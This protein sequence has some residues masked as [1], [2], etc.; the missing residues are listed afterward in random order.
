MI[1]IINSLI[2]TSAGLRE[3]YE[4]A[5]DGEV[6]SY[7]GPQRMGDTRDYKT[8][9]GG[10]LM[11]APGFV[12]THT[13]G[14][15]G[16]DFMDANLEGNYEAIKLHLAH[17]STSLMPT[18]VSSNLEE[19]SQA[20]S[21]IEQMESVKGLPSLL[22]VHIEGPYC[23]LSQS[24]AQNALFL[25]N[26][27]EEEYSQL[28][29]KHPTIKK[30]TIA[31]ELPGAL[32]MGNY[33]KK[34][35]VIASIGHSDAEEDHV[36]QAIENGYTMITHHFNGMSRLTRRN[37]K[38]YLGVAESGLLYDALTSEVIADG[39]HLPISLLKLIY[40][41]KGPDRICLVT[42]SIRA[43]GQNVDLSYI[44]SGEHAQKIVIEDGVAYMEGKTSFGGSIATADRLF[45]TMFLDAKIPLEDCVKMMT[46]TPLRTLGIK[47]VGSIETGMLADLVLFDEK[48]NILMVMARGVMCRNEI[49]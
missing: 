23:A 24:G 16:F 25:R 46:T 1:R 29:D 42:D 8:I 21:V 48:I 45:R 27:D 6:I 49:M 34:R 41:S 18:T 33:L 31:P 9:D 43:T 11:L 13:H 15:S 19:L 12:D 7:V 14:A 22:G 44:G 36:V 40:R 4:C 38:M 37:A 32:E 20:I 47:N 28:L 35:G 26:P 3:G 39:R 5:I 17:G 10:G 2:V 30:W